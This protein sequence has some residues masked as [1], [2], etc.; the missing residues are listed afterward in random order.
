MITRIYPSVLEAV[1][2]RGYAGCLERVFSGYRG[3]AMHYLGYELRRIPI[4]RTRMNKGERMSRWANTGRDEG[5]VPIMGIN[6]E[7]R[8]AG[9]RM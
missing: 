5:S 3:E 2:G 6:S 9:G 8:Q 4:P 1:S 7:R